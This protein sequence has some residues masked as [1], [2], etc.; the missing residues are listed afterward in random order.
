MKM[1]SINPNDAEKF[2]FKPASANADRVNSFTYL[3]DNNTHCIQ[4]ET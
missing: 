4:S 2:I 3:E 1:F